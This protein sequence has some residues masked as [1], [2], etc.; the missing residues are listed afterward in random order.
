[1]DVPMHQ[2]YGAVHLVRLF[3]E[4]LIFISDKC[5]FAMWKDTLEFRPIP[6]VSDNH[7]SFGCSVFHFSLKMSLRDS[8]SIL[9]LKGI[10]NS[11]NSYGLI[12]Q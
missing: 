2:I 12:I 1:M 11:S 9:N 5:L 7:N 8:T 3:G 4:I 6:S 10:N